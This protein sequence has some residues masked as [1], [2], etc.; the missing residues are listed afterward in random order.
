MGGASCPS[1]IKVPYQTIEHSDH[2]A[3]SFE[4]MEVACDLR[5]LDLNLLK[6]GCTSHP[7]TVN[8]ARL[9]DRQHGFDDNALMPVSPSWD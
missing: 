2:A 7:E 4:R 6:S 8:N 5:G 3:L 1:T 9:S